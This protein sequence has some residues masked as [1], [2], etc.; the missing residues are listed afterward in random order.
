M[1]NITQEWYIDFMRFICNKLISI[2]RHPTSITNIETINLELNNIV[3]FIENYNYQ[4][5]YNQLKYQLSLLSNDN[6]QLLKY[7]FKEYLHV[8]QN[9]DQFVFILCNFIADLLKD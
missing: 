7:I 6:K 8:L 9:I 1:N 4:P 2:H 3:I 5:N